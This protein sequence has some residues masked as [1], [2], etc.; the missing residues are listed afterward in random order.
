MRIWSTKDKFWILHGRSR[1]V[2]EG[3][4]QTDHTSNF[5]VHLKIFLVHLN[6]IFRACQWMN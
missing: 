4:H 3:M 1:G 2:E 6:R 5:L